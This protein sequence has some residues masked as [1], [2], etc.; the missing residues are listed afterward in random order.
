MKTVRN[1][2]YAGLSADE[3]RQ[4]LHGI[5]LMS[6]G[7]KVTLEPRRVN[8]EDRLWF[9]FYL[10]DAVQSSFGFSRRDGVV[11]LAMRDLDG[12][13]VIKE[14]EPSFPTVGSSSATKA[15]STNF[16]RVQSHEVVK[17]MFARS[18][19]FCRGN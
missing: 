16:I 2:I 4:I 5:R 14:R 12:E 15:R 17:E 10:S 11:R 6:L 3:A 18:L 19:Q 1:P 13:D 7:R 8:E 9:R